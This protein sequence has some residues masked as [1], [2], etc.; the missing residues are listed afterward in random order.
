VRG[1]GE[2][3]QVDGEEEDQLGGRHY[4]DRSMEQA[5]ELCNDRLRAVI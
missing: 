1:G 4:T 5:S 2:E 3:S